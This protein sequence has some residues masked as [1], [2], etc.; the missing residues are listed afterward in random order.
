MIKKS[1]KAN[2]MILLGYITIELIRIYV[3][4]SLNFMNGQFQ[5]SLELHRGSQDLNVKHMDQKGEIQRFI[6]L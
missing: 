6:L 1:G 2:T 3:I 4:N 5:I